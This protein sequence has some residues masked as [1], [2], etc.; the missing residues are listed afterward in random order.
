MTNSDLPD[1]DELISKFHL[2]VINAVRRDSLSQHKAVDE[3]FKATLLTRLEAE[4]VDYPIR[5]GR[6]DTV[7]AIPLT[8]LRELLK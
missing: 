2:E 1:V 6:L 8:K 5:V 4:A 7:Q 3:N